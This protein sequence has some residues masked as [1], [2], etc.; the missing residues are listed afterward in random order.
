MAPVSSVPRNGGA[1]QGSLRRDHSITVG[2]P[3][4]LRAINQ[5]TVLELIHR[6]GP[7]SRAQ[8]ARISGLSKPTVSL[9]LAG[10]LEAG[11]VREVGRSRGDR[12]PSAVL[13]E[14]NPL[15]GWVVGIDVGRKWVRAAIAD[16]AGTIVARRDERAKVSSAKTLIGQIG[17][18]A[19]RLASEAG[20]QWKQVNHAVLGSPGVFDPAHGYMAMAP[21]LP[22]WG[23]H[24]LV[25]AVRD[26]LGTNVNFENDVNL[27]ALAERVHGHGRNVSNFVFLSIGTGIG[28]ALV[29]DGHLYRGA[30]GAAGEVADIP[31]G[32]GD[33]HDPANRRRGAC[34]E[35]A[36]AAGIVRA[37]RRMGMRAP[38][39]PERIFIA[40]RKGNGSA[41][42]VVQAEAALLSLAIATVTQVVDP[43]LV[44]LGG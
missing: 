20:V 17:G 35:A 26:E 1:Q 38:L 10:L 39:T 22:G 24:G 7:L 44:I 18:I 41:T 23:R 4:L 30:H 28:M 21:N 16:I 27:S 43:E 13:Y 5:R 8:A 12:G 34:E 29:I 36:A 11:L 2:T 15:A 9:T 32:K 31:L 42:R 40:A 33:P 14:L 6:Q 19:R 25:E 3:S 37:A